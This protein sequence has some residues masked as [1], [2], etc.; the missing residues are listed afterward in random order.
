MLKTHDS[1]KNLLSWPL[2]HVIASEDGTELVESESSTTIVEELNKL[3]YNVARGRDF[4]GVHYC[5]DGNK[6]ILLGEMYAISYLRDKCLEYSEKFNGKFA[7]WTLS[8]FDG[9]IITIL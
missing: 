6:G 1:D 5:V 9:T 8:K 7:G 4:A 2:N 3:A